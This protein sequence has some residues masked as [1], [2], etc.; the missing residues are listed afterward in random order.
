MGFT[1]AKA[2]AF[3]WSYIDAFNKLEA[4]TLRAS[5]KPL[6]G[7]ESPAVEIN[8]YGTRVDVESFTVCDYFGIITKSLWKT[9]RSMCGST[10]T[11]S[12]ALSS[13]RAPEL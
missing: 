12:G 1:G 2:Q 5:A 4:S 6:L 10:P 3:K 13:R 7:V 8:L 11:C 9:S